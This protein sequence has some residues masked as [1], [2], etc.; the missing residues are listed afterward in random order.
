[1]ITV[2][3]D[4][5]SIDK[6][7]S[8]TEVDTPDKP[9]ISVIEGNLTETSFAIDRVSSLTLNT[10]GSREDGFPIMVNVPIIVKGEK[11][12]GVD[13]ADQP[14]YKFSQ[15]FVTNENGE[16]TIE[17][18]EWDNYYISVPDQSSYSISGLSKTM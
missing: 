8:N 16:L 17:N 18:L 2:T 4:G 9:H 12:I 15:E 11:T 7:Y 13:V 5:F 1:E 3:K 14:V 6:T 10:Y